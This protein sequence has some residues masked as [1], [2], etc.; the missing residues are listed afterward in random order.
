VLTLAASAATCTLRGRTAVILT[1]TTA[2]DQRRANA[3]LA[4]VD[5]YYAVGT[6]SGDRW[7]AAPEQVT[8]P[9]GEQS[10]VQDVALAL[11]GLIQRGLAP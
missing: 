5:A 3:E 10:I 8:A 2:A 9:S 7:S 1:F 4:R 6:T 11:R